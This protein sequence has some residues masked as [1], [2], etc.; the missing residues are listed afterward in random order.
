MA[1]LDDRPELGDDD[2]RGFYY[3]KRGSAKRE[4]DTERERQRER[5]R[6]RESETEVTSR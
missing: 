3:R 2:E 6:E 5:Q 1:T 4:R